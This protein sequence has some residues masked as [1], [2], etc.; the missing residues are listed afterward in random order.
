[1]KKFI[2]ILIAFFILFNSTGL[3]LLYLRMQYLFK[4]EAREL[5][6]Q[7]KSE[8]NLV[9]IKVLKKDIEK[10]YST[11]DEDEIF[12][13]NAKY[14]IFKK[15]EDNNYY[16]FYC[17]NDEYENK[18]DNAFANFLVNELSDK[19]AKKSIIMVLSSLITIGF[20]EIPDFDIQLKNNP[21]SFID[22]NAKLQFTSFEVPT[23]P[24]RQI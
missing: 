22:K 12:Y 8:D 11:L 24:P 23:P 1:M 19:S 20:N 18:L 14:D 13:E 5:I 6:S 21:V 17:L 9:L 4:S 10:Y 7:I 3:M 16:Y 15:S 2:C